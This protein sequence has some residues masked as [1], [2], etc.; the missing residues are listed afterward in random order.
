MKVIRLRMNSL[1][2]I[3]AHGGHTHAI[4]PE[5]SPDRLG[6]ISAFHASLIARYEKINPSAFMPW[7]ANSTVTKLLYALSPVEVTGAP[8]RLFDLRIA[9]ANDKSRVAGGPGPRA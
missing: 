4:A 7:V 6:W 8:E 5:R 9:S 1:D 3:S 2:Q